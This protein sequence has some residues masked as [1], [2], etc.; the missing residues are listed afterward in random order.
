MQPW[1]WSGKAVGSSL[2]RA[3]ADT[4]G[5]LEE[6]AN[7]IHIFSSILIY[8]YFYKKAEWNPECDIPHC[9]TISKPSG[10][11]DDPTVVQQL[12]VSFLSLVLFPLIDHKKKKLDKVKGIP[13]EHRAP[14]QYNF[15]LKFYI[16]KI[17]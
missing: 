11:C 10:S 13:R 7:N 1:G 9:K 3:R 12:C 5:V 17:I 15:L 6:D 16:L 8:G 2:Q 14:I 4:M